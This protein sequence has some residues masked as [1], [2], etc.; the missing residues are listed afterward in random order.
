MESK[1]NRIRVTA[2]PSRNS[3]SRARR[4]KGCVS[5]FCSFLEAATLI[6]QR[7]VAATCTLPPL[8]PFPPL[9]IVARSAQLMSEAKRAHGA[10]MVGSRTPSPPLLVGMLACA[11]L[12]SPMTL[13]L[14]IAATDFRINWD[15]GAA[16]PSTTGSWTCPARGIRFRRRWLFFFLNNLDCSVN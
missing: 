4:C 3:L 10:I 15:A 8:S 11:H 16:S 13:L 2:S 12:S 5:C 14:T 1:V 7:D 6:T 9:C